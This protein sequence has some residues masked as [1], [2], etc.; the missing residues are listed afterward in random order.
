MKLKISDY[1]KNN[2][3]FEC[4]INNK[5]YETHFRYT[6]DVKES[7]LSNK[8]ISF[9]KVYESQ[10]EKNPIIFFL[11]TT[12]ENKIINNKDFQKIQENLH[13]YFNYY[14]NHNMERKYYEYNKKHQD[15][16]IYLCK[17]IEELIK[18]LD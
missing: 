1:I 8:I 7:E 2:Y 5:E 9:L 12:D 11:N 4:Y 13:I 18:K 17:I 10:K 6:E 3:E 15:I 16:H 14:V